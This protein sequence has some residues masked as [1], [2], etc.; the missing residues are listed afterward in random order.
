MC[1][2]WTLCSHVCEPNLS[3]KFLE[4]E[5]CE[6]WKTLDFGLCK[7]WN[8][9]ENSFLLSVQ[10]LFLVFALYELPSSDNVFYLQ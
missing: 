2:F 8:V 9:L 7:S 5:F 3:W 4:N 6:Y 1:T 10:T